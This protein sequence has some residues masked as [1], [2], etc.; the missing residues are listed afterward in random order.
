[1]ES[2]YRDMLVVSDMDGTLLQ[3]GYGIPKEN[4]DAIDAFV[5]KGGLF[6]VATGRS[7]ESVGKYVD[8]LHFSA[9]AILCNGGMIYD[10]DKKEILYESVLDPGAKEI[11]YDVREHFPDMGIEVHIGGK[12]VAVH[13]NEHILNHTAAEHISFTLR[14]IESIGDRW[15]KIFFSDSP[16]AVAALKKYT[17][18]QCR[19]DGNYA[20]F[21]YFL[22]GP[23]KYEVM[24]KGINKGDGLRM[25]AKL[26]G[27]EIKKTVAIGDFD[28][29][30]PLMKVAGCAV[31]VADGTPEARAAADIVVCSCLQGG[32]GELLNSID[33]IYD[34]YTQMKLE[35]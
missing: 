35:L 23:T 14:D 19:T 11:V 1:M 33:D 24:P 28:N 10:F 6:T 15:N 31:A 3:A 25:L 13:M 20:Q 7:I 4:I 27:I 26:L 30:I 22:T 12:I 34:G 18:E 32:V 2:R 9:P 5:K 17:E 21:D 16:E 8:W 29:D